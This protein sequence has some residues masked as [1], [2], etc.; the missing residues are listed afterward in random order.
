MFDLLLR[1]LVSLNG[2]LRMQGISMILGGGMGLFLRDSFL[3]GDRSPHYPIRPESRS[4]QDLDML[5]TA[6]LII[7]ADKMNALRDILKAGGYEPSVKF[8]QF[9][10]KVE[11]HPVP[12]TVKVDLLAAPPTSEDQPAQDSPSKK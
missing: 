11:T 8:F 12:R 4:T 1:E 7:D 6:D 10:R 5:L 9:E 2:K 3:G